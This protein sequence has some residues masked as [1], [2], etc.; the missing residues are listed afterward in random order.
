MPHMIIEPF[1]VAYS[2]ATSR[3]VLRVDAADRRHRLGR[4]R[5]HVLGERI[6]SGRPIADE[7]LVDQSLFDDDVEHR[8]QQGDV[9]IGVELE[10]VGRMASEIAAARVGDDQL[11]AVFGGVLHEGRGHRVIHRGVRAD[12]E[13]HFCLGDV[14][15][16]DSRRPRS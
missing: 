5:L 10:I 14:A 9:G 6:V 11:R 16:L 8:V 15:Y 12:H 3:I 4:E 1:D 7:R 13:D 2:L